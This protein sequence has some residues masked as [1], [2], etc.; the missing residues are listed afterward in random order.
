[1]IFRV[2]PHSLNK[3]LLGAHRATRRPR[4]QKKRA[5]LPKTRSLPERLLVRHLKSLFLLGTAS[6]H[7]PLPKRLLSS[8]EFLWL[9][10]LDLVL[11]AGSFVRTSKNIKRYRL[12]PLLRRRTPRNPRQQPY[13][14][15]STRLSL[16]CVVQSVPALHNPSKSCHII[17]SPS[18]LTWTRL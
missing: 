12:W 7:P 14:I 1:M 15:M 18:R 4:N 5:H 11:G 17:I 13:L 6:S 8:A 16:T 9:K 2:R 3:R 10:C